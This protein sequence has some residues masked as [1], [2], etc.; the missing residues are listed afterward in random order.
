MTTALRRWGLFTALAAL[1]GGGLVLLSSGSGDPVEPRTDP[2]AAVDR[3]K[4]PQLRGSPNQSRRARPA[5]VA[6]SWYPGDREELAELV[7]GLLARA[8]PPALAGKGPV[9]ALI[10][11]HA[12]FRFSGAA[13]ADGFR[14]LKG[15]QI[16]RVV[17]L[18]P[19]HR[20]GF[21]GLSIAEVTHYATPLGDIP[22]DTG[23]IARLRHHPLVKAHPAAHRGEHSIEM[24]LPLLQRT[25]PAG[26]S[27]VPILV[28]RLDRDGI[29]R[30]AEL[31]RL[32]ADDRTLFVASS[33][34][35]HYG[36]NYDYQP[37]PQDDQV[38]QRLRELDM[39]AL[40]LIEA[41][42]SDGLASYRETTGINVCGQGPVRILL[43]ILPPSAAATLVRYTTSGELLGDYTNSV[44]YLTVAFTA[45]Q[46][47][48]F[49]GGP[50]DL[51][52]GHL[53]LLHQ[54]A[55]RALER[56]VTSGTDPSDA[57]AL[58][59]GLEIPSAL[60]QKRAAFVTLRKYG[61]LR[62]CI[63]HL[64]PIDPLI[65]SVMGNAVN[66]AL[67]DNRFPPVGPAELSELTVEISVLSAT[68][69]IQQAAEFR[70]G[71]EGVILMKGGRRAVFLPE[72]A[73]ERGWDR[74]ETLSALSRKA[75]LPDDGWQ[76]DAQF[77]VFTAQVYEAPFSP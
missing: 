10:S 15:Q 67:R 20:G 55:R 60:K 59:A 75:G 34:F 3:S 43:G 42:D 31:L 33:D 70:V 30:A 41:R 72:V 24:Q 71:K 7:D 73:A 39:G 29:A 68:H 6:G 46:P 54:L 12:G 48:S 58:T 28:G 16:C 52:L 26:W 25:L 45:E 21:T 66:A 57:D 22:L 56:G 62:G 64:Q 37:F 27:L 44:S 4:C 11:P 76:S 51:P 32:L 47:L 61:A 8:K 69:S 18:G 63:G 13:A 9:R 35:T 23:A 38:A 49:S 36:S 5:A 74:A 77:E 40:R 19:A 50:D 17:V 1:L 53:Q 14:L 2:A 65:E